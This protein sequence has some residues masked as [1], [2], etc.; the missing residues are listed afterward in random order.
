MEVKSQ[1][2]E[3]GIQ[4]WHLGKKISLKALPYNNDII[5]GWPGPL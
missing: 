5:T 3:L 2:L 4:S 1:C